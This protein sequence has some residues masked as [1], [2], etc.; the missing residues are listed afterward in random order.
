M[1]RRFKLFA[2]LEKGEK[3]DALDGISYGLDN[4]TIL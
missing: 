1:P 3:G 4:S 2:E